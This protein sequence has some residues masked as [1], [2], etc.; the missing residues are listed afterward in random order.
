LRLNQRLQEDEPVTSPATIVPV[1]VAD[2][3]AEGEPMPV[4]AH[5]IPNQNCSALSG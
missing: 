3:L 4:N 5:V 1:F 2:L